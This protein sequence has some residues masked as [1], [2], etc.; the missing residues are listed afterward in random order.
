MLA[1]C[2]LFES[3]D[4]DGSEASSSREN[5]EGLRPPVVENEKSCGSSG[6]ASLVMVIDAGKMTASLDSDRSWLPP[7]LSRSRIRMWN[8]EPEMETAEAPRPQ[9]TRV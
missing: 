4:G 7:L 5:D 6:E 8:G 9:S 1:N 3:V 2:W